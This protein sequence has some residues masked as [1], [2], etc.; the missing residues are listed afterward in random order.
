MDVSCAEKLSNFKKILGKVLEY[1]F[2]CT[3][4]RTFDLA[5]VLESP[6][7][8]T[9]LRYYTVLSLNKPIFLCHDEYLSEIES[10]I[11]NKFKKSKK[12]SNQ[13]KNKTVVLYC[14]LKKRVKNSQTPKLPKRVKNSQ[15]L[16]LPKRIK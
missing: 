1:L 11:E 13:D 6:H 8:G 16:K 2:V 7:H 10:K 9:I 3:I 14:S 5:L 4:P 15:T 12:L